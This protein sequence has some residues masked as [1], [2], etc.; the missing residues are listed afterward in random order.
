M[1]RNKDINTQSPVIIIKVFISSV[2][3][4]PS[5]VQH[6]PAVKESPKEHPKI[7]GILK[8]LESCFN[9]VL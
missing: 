2:V 3:N 8:I 7:A 4:L 5:F 1:Y 9:P 6:M